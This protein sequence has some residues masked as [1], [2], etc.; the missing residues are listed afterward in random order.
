MTTLH[1]KIVLITG[2]TRGIGLGIAR[3]FA[4]EGA[5]IICCGT[6]KEKAEEVSAQIRDEFSVESRGYQVD[7]SS[8]ESTQALVDAVLSQFGRID[9]LVNN[10]GITRDNLMLRMSWEEWDSVIRTNLGSVYSMTKPVLKAMLKQRYGRIVNMSSVIGLMGNAGQANYAAAKAGIIGF[11]KSIAKEYGAK[12]I[13]CNVVAPGFI[14]TEMTASLSQNQ[15]EAIIANVP[16]RR[17]GVVDDVA[18]L[19]VFLAQDQAGYITGQVVQVDGG[20]LM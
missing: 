16:V 11:S 19:V 8:V 20:M 5:T 10:A 7:V 18:A 17:L 12:G 3:H 9:V 2:S 6:K 4:K 1:K 15:L 14:E 13:T